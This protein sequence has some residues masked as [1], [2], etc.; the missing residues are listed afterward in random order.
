ME[1]S[2][3]VDIAIWGIASLTSLYASNKYRKKAEQAYIRTRSAQNA[4][5]YTNTVDEIL[6]AIESGLIA[7]RSRTSDPHT[8]I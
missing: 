2:E 7:S 1:W 8:Q 6:N 5:R 4:S 3:F